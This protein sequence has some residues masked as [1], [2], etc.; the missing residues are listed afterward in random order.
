MVDLTRAIRQAFADTPG[1]LLSHAPQ[2]PYLTLEPVN[3]PDDPG[4]WGSYL[5]ILAQVGHMIDFLNIQAYNN[6]SY[7]DCPVGAQIVNNLLAA[8]PLPN[9]LP[10]VYGNLPQVPLA[11]SQ[12][13]Y[14]QLVPI[15]PP[16]PGSKSPATT[17][18]CAGDGNLNRGS[19]MMFWLNS[20][21]TGPAADAVVDAWFPRSASQLSP[22]N[23]VIYY[24]NDPLT[25]TPPTTGY[26][27]ANTI[28]LGFIYPAQNG[29]GS[30]PPCPPG[31]SSPPWACFGFYY[32]FGEQTNPLVLA[33]ATYAQR[34]V[35]W[36]AVEPTKRKIMVGLGGAASTPPYA[37]W[38][39]GNNVSIVA[40]GLK[41][42]FHQFEAVNGFAL[43]GLDLDYEDGTALAYHPTPPQLAGLGIL[44]RE[45]R[46]S[47]HRSLFSRTP[48]GI[49]TLCLLAA[50]VIALVVALAVPAAR[51]APY[52]RNPA[53]AAPVTIGA[54]LAIASIAIVATARR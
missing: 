32:A 28:I 1:F 31:S 6:C 44:P 36:R 43:D 35:A 20:N 16:C 3:D 9:P 47:P 14:G 26:S 51:H 5:A 41:Q 50:I 7:Q 13:A 34:L 24:L 39:T 18:W 17:P 49:A 11:P 54:A 8:S 19:G 42:F 4:Y 10:P 27:R 22:P 33:P 25:Y 30:N 48:A 2:T 46:Y 53:F 15:T 29:G 21:N 38:A 52:I 12:V 23:R 40:A 37:T 45:P